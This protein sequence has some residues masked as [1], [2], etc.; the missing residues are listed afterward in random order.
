ML[1]L[2]LF[3][4][5]D[6]DKMPVRS[7]VV[8]TVI[9]PP[10]LGWNTRDSVVDMDPRY[11]IVM[12]NYF[13]AFGTVDLVKGYRY[14]SKSIGS[15]AVQAL[16]VLKT[17]DYNKLVAVGSDKFV[18]DASTASSAATKI[19]LTAADNVLTSAPIYLQFFK[20]RLF[21][22]CGKSGGNDFVYS[23]TGTGDAL[24]AGFT[25]SGGTAVGLGPMATY[26]YRL[27]FLQNSSA[28]TAAI[29]TSLF[30]SGYDSITGALTE[31]PF[32][33]FLRLGGYGVFVGSVTRAKDFSEDELLCIITDQGEILVYEGLYPGSADWNL[34][35]HYV[36]PRPLGPKAF[37]YIG[38]NL[39]IITS[40][41]LIPMS[42]VMGGTA[43]GSYL[44][45]SDAITPSF[46][47]A[48][49]TTLLE[50]TA[51][52]G[53]NFPRGNFA[54]CNIP[55]TSGA[56]SDQYYMNTKT[57]AWC[58]RTN[59]NAFCWAI[60]GD[61]LYFG[62]LSGRVFKAHNGTFDENPASE[63]ATLSK[64][65]KLRTAFNYFDDP[66]SVKKF[67]HV[68]PIVYESNGLT[69]MIDMDVDYADRTPSS[70]VT[71]LGDNS[72]K[73]YRPMCGLSAIG[74]AGSVHVEM[75]EG[76]KRRSFQA[77]EVFYNQGDVK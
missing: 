75:G 36:V 53:V 15:G 74:K 63:G 66:R 29:N 54:V 22:T 2:G 30:Y 4:M 18:Y 64:T 58:R 14:H 49:T 71:N 50:D 16:A 27:Y 61:E 76:D 1:V 34:V 35:G 9:P 77:F 12:D 10:T 24:S 59:Q 7:P 31:F 26:K 32:K 56:T 23:W 6:G 55:V 47:D 72:Y 11:A 48:A 51:W 20:D 25:I 46:T 69:M 44:T 8:S 40:Q 67:T 19:K 3:Q 68:R 70:T 52:C 5:V 38:A 45:L 39:C 41:G 60:Y 43:T 17:T 37:F 28:T 42:E 33:S 73:V 65:T 21:I 57:Q 13:P 62:G